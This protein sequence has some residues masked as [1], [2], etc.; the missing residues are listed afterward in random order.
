MKYFKSQQSFKLEN[1]EQLPG[2]TIA[3]TTYGSLNKE[4]NN[5]IWICHA[6]TANSNAQEWWPGLVGD[7]VAFDTAKHFIVSAN[8]LGS[9]YGTTGPASRPF[10]T[11]NEFYH[12]FPA[13]TIRDM[14]Q[15]HQ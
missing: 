3:Y 10:E 6:L 5:V 4:R 14:V 13:I 9:C 15:A 2:I 7:G 8:I 11:G 12:D 1:G